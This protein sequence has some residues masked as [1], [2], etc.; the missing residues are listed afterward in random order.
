LGFTF[1]I[2]IDF[3]KIK[4]INPLI[5][6]YFRNHSL[7]YYHSN[8]DVLL[9]D[10][11]TIASKEVKQYKGILFEFEYDILYI[12][13]KPHY[14]Y[15]DNI[16][17]ANDFSIVSCI[18]VL[19]R[20]KQLFEV[21]FSQLDIINIEFGVNLVFPKNL[22]CVKEL[23]INLIYHGKN[24]FY[25]DRKYPFCRFSNSIRVNG[26]T[27]VYKIIKC[28]AKGLQFPQF[29][30]INTFRF[31]VKS[32]RRNYIQSLGI[33]TL[34]D[35]TT[36]KTYDFLSEIIIKEFDEVLIIDETTKPNLTPVKLK[37]FNNKINPLYW[38]K[39]LMFG[40]RNA[41]RKNFKL[42]Y[43]QLNYC[44]SHVKKEVKNILIDKLIE[45]KKVQF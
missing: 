38:R 13:F 27:N 1:S 17:N 18:E 14:F 32:N 45:L 34:N 40:N 42:Y 20:F 9:S 25:T 44:F 15:N 16:H 35:L 39:L 28:Y 36:S 11:E 3:L 24:E 43:K 19:L 12:K 2:L 26:S 8:L 29:T 23:L 4:V 37:N 21:D 10:R 31:E 6:E 41:F 33:F 22:I 5:V 7:L 30:D